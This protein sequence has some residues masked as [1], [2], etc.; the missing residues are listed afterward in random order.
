MKIDAMLIV[1]IVAGLLLGAAGGYLLAPKTDVTALENRIQTLETTAQQNQNQIHDLQV[2]AAEYEDEIT[3]M[4]GQLE[5]A[6]VDYST[7]EGEYSELG[8]DNQQLINTLS[9]K[10]TELAGLYTD[11]SSF[12]TQITDLQEQITLLQELTLTEIITV[13]FSATENTEALLVEWIDKANSS[14]LLMVNRIVTGNLSE[15]LINAYNRGVLMQIII[16]SDEKYTQGSAFTDL[17]IAGTDIRGDNNLYKMNNKAMILDNSIVVT[18]SYDWTP[19]A[20]ITQDNNVILLENEQVT[21][22]YSS[23]FERIWNQTSLETLISTNPATYII[24]NEVEMNP[25]G[26]DSGFEW[27]ELYNPTN[28]TVDISLWWVTSTAGTPYGQYIP[29]GTEIESNEYYILYAS[30]QWFDNPGDMIRLLTYDQEVIDY[31][32]EISEST[33]STK[34]WQRIPNGYDSDSASDWF[35]AEETKGTENLLPE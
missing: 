6:D 32:P 29:W 12:Q 9:T 30:Q 17:L 16:D 5:Q 35:Y 15:A 33:D 3:V 18:G 4:T 7:L 31:T 22:L 23:E 19:N 26:S 1:G 34:T 14:I 13:S 27:V 21:E 11:V 10:N 24:I 20:E 28:E 25:V 2:Q 8:E